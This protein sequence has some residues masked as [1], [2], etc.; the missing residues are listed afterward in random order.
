MKALSII[1]PWPWLIMRHGKDVENRSWK[2]SYRGRLLIHA[3]KKPDDNLIQIL[4]RH[5]ATPTEDE[6]REMLEWRGHIVG[7]VE[8]VDCV[9]DSKSLWAKDGMWHWVLRD[10]SPCDLIP[11]K[12]ALGLWEHDDYEWNIHTGILPWQG[13]RP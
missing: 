13:D 4:S 11:I 1:M 8:L 6:L 3:S 5:R 10:P 12:G 9:Q 7:S 2:T